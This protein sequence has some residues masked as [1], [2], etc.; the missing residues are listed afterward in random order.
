MATA[1]AK[2]TAPAVKEEEA[3]D[4]EETAGTEILFSKSDIAEMM[5]TTTQALA[6]RMKREKDFPRPT[7]SNKGGTMVLYSKADVKK[8]HEFMTA[9]DKERTK[10]LAEALGEL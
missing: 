8:V 1:N 6:N 10:K 3:V 5:G 7:Y 4:P 9:A 2:T